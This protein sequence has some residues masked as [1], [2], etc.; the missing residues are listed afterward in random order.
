IVASGI[1][2]SVRQFCKAAFDHL[3]LN[4]E[5]YVS[6]SP[7][8]FRP[9]DSVNLEGNAQK[10]KALGWSTSLSFE[11]LVDKMVDSDLALLQGKVVST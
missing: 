6:T 4:Y 10:L 3:N 8:F 7:E 5:D 11:Q 1:S 2:R 9:I